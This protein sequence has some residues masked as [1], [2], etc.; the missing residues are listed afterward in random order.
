M[1]QSE[2]YKA[3]QEAWQGSAMPAD[4]GPLPDLMHRLGGY[5]DHMKRRNRAKMAAIALI[6]S[7]MLAQ[8]WLRPLPRHPWPLFAGLGLVFFGTIAFLAFYMHGQFQLAAIDFTA[9]AL[10]FVRR[11]IASLERERRLFRVHFPAFLLLLILA[12]NVMAMSAWPAHSLRFLLGLH[13][14]ISLGL[15]IAGLAGWMYRRALFRRK[16]GPL[17]DELRETEV[18]WSRG[19]GAAAGQGIMHT[20]EKK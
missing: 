16:A 12:V 4:A 13:M 1:N 8:L 3:W 14:K 11:I 15:G 9:P 6:F 17:L 5:E 10:E 20:D 19:E 7:G 18:S 2:S